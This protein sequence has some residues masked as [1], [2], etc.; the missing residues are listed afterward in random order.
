MNLN[1]QKLERYKSSC[2]YLSNGVLFSL[3][4]LVSSMYACAVLKRA[5]KYSVK[6]L[7]R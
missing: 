3:A 1:N 2:F 6:M 4:P 7:Q 5:L